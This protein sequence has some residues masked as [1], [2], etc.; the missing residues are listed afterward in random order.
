MWIIVFLNQV[1]VSSAEDREGFDISQKERLR[2]EVWDSSTMKIVKFTEY[3]LSK[4]HKDL[5]AKY[6]APSPLSTNSIE[7]SRE[8]YKDYMHTMLYLEEEDCNQKIS[9]FASEVHLKCLTKIKLTDRKFELIAYGGTMYGQVD[10]K[11][12][13]M[14]DSETSQIIER[15]V[16]RMMLKFN[17]SETVCDYFR[18]STWKRSAWCI[19]KTSGSLTQI[20]VTLGPTHIWVIMTWNLF[21]K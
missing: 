16:Q 9:K 1:H 6:K 4:V 5:M 8:S 18:K 20:R 7:L 19:L 13:L 3:K 10:L 2:T 21:S 12:V 11:V 17:T 15:S 14:D